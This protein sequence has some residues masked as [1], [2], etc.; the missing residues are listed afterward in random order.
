[1]FL[2]AMAS[3]LGVGAVIVFAGVWM[4]KGWH[5]AGVLARCVMLA[6][7][8]A[9]FATA[10]VS[11]VVAIPDRFLSRAAAALPAFLACLV[12]LGVYKVRRDSWARRPDRWGSWLVRETAGVLFVPL[13]IAVVGAS[14]LSTGAFFIAMQNGPQ[15]G[16]LLPELGIV[17]AACWAVVTVGG[18][19]ARGRA[20]NAGSIARRETRQ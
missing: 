16:S 11:L 5:V 19:W 2:L 4:V 17:T 14:V 7:L 18:V 15:P 3:A 6:L 8:A 12:L 20:P 10:F 9:A 13:G 1:M